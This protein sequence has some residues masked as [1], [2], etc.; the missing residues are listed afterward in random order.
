MERR[1]PSASQSRP[2]QRPSVRCLTPPD[3]YRLRAIPAPPGEQPERADP[4]TLGGQI[5]GQASRTSSRRSQLEREIRSKSSSE[6]GL[7]GRAG[8]EP[9]QLSRRFYRPLGSPRALCRPTG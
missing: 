1:E 3:L 8:V 4:N 6:L 5:G 9:A 2:S 7:V